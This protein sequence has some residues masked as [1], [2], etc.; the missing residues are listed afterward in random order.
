MEQM[1]NR[2]LWGQL[3]AAG[4]FGRGRDSRSLM[5][6]VEALRTP[7]RRWMRES[8]EVLTRAGFLVRSG[9]GYAEAETALPDVTELWAQWERL[10]GDWLANPD[11][12][13]QARLAERTLRALPDI[14]AGRVKATEVLFPGGTMELV[15]GI[16]KHNRTADYYNGVLGDMV[17]AYMEEIS[18]ERRAPGGSSKPG[19]RILEIGAGTGGTSAEV[20][21]RLR[22]YREHVRE[23]CYTDMSK[24]F[25]AHAQRAYG[26]ENPYLTV[27]I[28]NA[29]LPYGEQG[30]ECG[31]YDL[32]IAANVLHATANIRRTLRNCKG[33][34]K[35]NGLL[36]LNEITSNTVFA[37]VTFGL[38]DGWWLYEDDA[39]R[40]P[41]SPCLDEAEWK[42]ALED[43]GFRSVLF[44][45]DGSKGQQII[46]SESDGIIRQPAA[47]AKMEAAMPSGRPG[48]AEQSV[49]PERP[50]ATASF[51]SESAGETK[52][53]AVTAMHA[54]QTGVRRHEEASPDEVR[55]YVRTTIRTQLEQSLQLTGD[56]IDDDDAF[57]DY[58]LDSITG[59]QLVKGLNQTLGCKLSIADLFDHS[60]VRQLASHLVDRYGSD[61][62]PPRI[63][64]HAE[65]AEASEP[66]IPVRGEQYER[67]VATADY[68]IAVAEQSTQAAAANR[69]YAAEQSAQAAAGAYGR[70]SEGGVPH[71]ETATRT[72]AAEQS[73]QAVGGTHGRGSE[74]GAAPRTAGMGPIAVIGLSGRFATAEDVSQLWA[75]LAAGDDLVKEATRWD[76]RQ[77]FPNREPFAI[78]GGFLDRIDEFD[79]SFF[80]IPS[81]EADYMDPQQRIFLEEA[82]K[83]LEDAG[84]AGEAMEGRRCGVY[85]GCQNGEYHQLYGEGAPSQALWGMS[86]SLIPSRIAYYLDLHGPA[87]AVDTACSSSLVAIHLACQGLWTGETEM[88]LAG[89]VSVRISPDFHETGNAAGLLSARGRCFSFDDRA[90]GFVLGEGA[91]AVVLK[92]LA[93][94]IADGDHIYGV[95]QGSGMNQDGRTNGITAP[96]AKSQERLVRGVYDNFGIDPTTIQLVEAHGSGTQLGDAIEIEAL[97]RVF[98]SSTQAIGFCAVGSLKSNIGHTAT[99]SGV[100]GLIKILLSMQKRQMPPTLHYENGNANID[101]G[102]SP[103]YVN[104]RLTPWEAPNGAKRRAAL[105]AFG[106]NGT[107]AHLVVEEAPYRPQPMAD[108]RS[109]L[110]ALSARTADQLRLQVERLIE[111]IRRNRP[112]SLADISFTLLTGRKHYGHRLACAARSSIELL[113]RL[114]RWLTAGQSEDVYASARAVRTGTQD[115]PVLRLGQECLSRCAAASAGEDCEEPV[116]TLAR[117][118]AEGCPLPYGELFRDG[119][120]CR[121]PLPGYPL[122]R[123]RYWVPKR[124]PKQ[125]AAQ[126]VAVVDSKSEPIAVVGMSGVFPLS[127]HED[128]HRSLPGAGDLNI[129]DPARFDPR[130][131]GLSP[132]QA[133]SM[134]RH[135]RLVLMHGWK[136]IE[137]AGYAP[138]S[139]AGSR[140]A[141]FVGVDGASFNGRSSSASPILPG[142]AAT[143]GTGANGIS[144][145]LDLHGPSETTDTAGSSALVAINRAVSAIRSGDC[146]A[147]LVGGVSTGAAVAAVPLG[148]LEAAAAIE[149]TGIGRPSAI[150]NEQQEKVENEGES[151]GVLLLKKLSAAERDGDAIHA[152]IRAS[153]VGHSGRSSASGEPS[154]SALSRLLA[155]AYG[156]ADV[157]L[158]A[159]THMELDAADFGP[160]NPEAGEEL[161]AVF[162]QACLTAGETARQELPFSVGLSSLAGH[163]AG[164]A[165]VM[166]ALQLLR[167]RQTA[168]S[169]HSVT[170]SATRALEA[171]HRGLPVQVIREENG[172]VQPRLAGI[173]AF[174]RGGVN[175]HVVVEEYTP[176]Q[177]EPR[178]R[179]IAPEQPGVFLLSAKDEFTLKQQ[180]AELL[181]AVSKLPEEKIDDAAFTLQTGRNAMEARLAVVAGSFRELQVKLGAYLS[182]MPDEDGVYVG[183]VNP[184]NEAIG[185]LATDD[186]D[187]GELIRQW[188]SKRK[189]ARLLPL[190]V[191]GLEVDWAR[192]YGGGAGRPY[193]LSLPTYPFGN[194]ERDWTAETTPVMTAARGV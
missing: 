179:I 33:A 124:E 144:W 136:A 14:L 101:F 100:A 112:E 87:I 38:L 92:R 10:S 148:L 98:R 59:I 79:A 17:E 57:S 129:A 93:D 88:A 150:G 184:D 138:S 53:A 25:L 45:A 175:A 26:N 20:L 166:S 102:Q 74:D 185:L 194:G 35:R 126:G 113:H 192:M 55:G 134:E 44:A 137:D 76:L 4:F 72:Y 153:A 22:P 39:V 193:R 115:E 143:L 32:V 48:P 30:L 85:V 149:G 15:E 40:I 171:D 82:W 80:N 165:S 127:Q 176:R 169:N 186:E 73:A 95:I 86:P 181:A 183:R 7:H 131:F 52:Q 158:G 116:R 8:L 121:V 168:E 81:H 154:A 99:A 141:V 107:N 43:E 159:V 118:F 90:D 71:R 24:A 49:P 103:F 178:A 146:E 28:L 56:M 152:V 133:A 5:E 174:G 41:G 65:R 161:A 167:Q 27:R 97:T 132:E 62:R 114:E 106:L 122:A 60:S 128:V 18:E 11:L 125:D 173:T 54:S 157:E 170:E 163:A 70:G 91:G 16:Y 36:L 190:W 29:E 23:Y 140:M 156:Q 12:A 42:R 51:Q 145:M 180:T 66:A 75:H 155:A 172:E 105:S 191:Q 50:A 147:A 160:A 123:E 151:V 182:G 139:M 46:V 142:S 177:R 69:T 111:F 130:V 119:R 117:L 13:A 9:N 83:A 89:G 162:G 34:L 189:F 61:I 96:S 3:H 31:V 108:G 21:R 135:H 67:E 64:G 68:P 109:R 84:Y 78:Q 77:A 47:F 164:M 2:M 120:Y 94:A 110:I 104:T 187:C 37:H 63:A 58:G 1:L 188:L 19:I 6:Q